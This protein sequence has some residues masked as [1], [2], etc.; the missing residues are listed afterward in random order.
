MPLMRQFCVRKMASYIFTLN[1]GHL[2]PSSIKRSGQARLWTQTGVCERK[3]WQAFYHV[4]P[5]GEDCELI[6]RL[7]SNR[8]I[9]YPSPDRY[10]L[11]NLLARPQTQPVLQCLVCDICKRTFCRRRWMRSVHCSCLLPPLQSCFE[12]AEHWNSQVEL[13]VRIS[14]S[15][16][17]RRRL[18]CILPLARRV[19]LSMLLFL[20]IWVCSRFCVGHSTIPK[21]RYRE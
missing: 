11:H 13:S 12:F 14:D 3:L 6:I 20:P 21:L 1:Y 19:V 10:S 2:S 15:V 5:R 8:P 9:A 17:C 18:C 16:S 7:Q 4:P